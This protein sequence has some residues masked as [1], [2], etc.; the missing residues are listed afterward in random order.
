MNVNTCRSQPARA[1]LN[2]EPLRRPLSRSQVAP[3]FHV[4]V[5]ILVR[6]LHYRDGGDGSRAA[7][8]R[9]PLPGVT[10]AASRTGYVRGPDARVGSF[11]F[12]YVVVDIVSCGV[13]QHARSVTHPNR[14]HVQSVFPTSKYE[15]N[16]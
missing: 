7:R 11:P 3:T 9:D 15:T 16:V 6:Y 4:C 14:A 2:A 8:P 10:S 1:D 12:N 13:S 5:E